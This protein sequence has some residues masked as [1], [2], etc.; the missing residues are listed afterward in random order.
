M[1][2][3][4]SIIP[5]SFAYP[6]FSYPNVEM[7][8]LKYMSANVTLLYSSHILMEFCRVWNYKMLN[9]YMCL[10]VRDIMLSDLQDMFTFQVSYYNI[11]YN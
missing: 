4:Y 5:N 11:Y 8:L 9:F 2:I 10:Q 3:M 7:W 1:Q 6:S